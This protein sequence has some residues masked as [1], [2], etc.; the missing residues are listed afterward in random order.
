M[1]H[2][3]LMAQRRAADRLE[4]RDTYSIKNRGWARA[5]RAGRFCETSARTGPDVL[6]GSA[7]APAGMVPATSSGADACIRWCRRSAPSPTLFSSLHAVVT[8]GPRLQIGDADHVV[9]GH[10]DGDMFGRRGG[11]RDLSPRRRWP[12]ELV[13]P[14]EAV[15]IFAGIGRILE[16]GEML[17]ARKEGGAALSG[18]SADARQQPVE[19]GPAG[20]G[21]Q[22]SK[23]LPGRLRRLRSP[24][25]RG[26][27]RRRRR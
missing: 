8:A 16:I 27:R 19:I 4:R 9:I 18:N 12:I 26:R 13:K 17:D 3:A 23:R 7:R 11:E 15:E 22:R 5:A 1:R 14:G 6:P 24:A 10:G 20:G 25:A 21:G 2:F